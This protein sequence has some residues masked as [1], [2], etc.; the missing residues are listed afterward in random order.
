MLPNGLSQ[1]KIDGSTIPYVQQAKNLGLLMTPSLNCQPQ[2]TSITNKVYT[3][4]SN[5]SLNFSLRKPLI[6]T[7]ALPHFG[8][9]SI[10]FMN[11]G[12]T[13]ALALQA[14]YTR[15]IFGNIPRIPTTNITS[16]LTQCR[17]HLDKLSIVCRHHLKLASLA[18]S[19]VTKQHPPYLLARLKYTPILLYDRR[20]TRTPRQHFEYTVRRTV[21]WKKSFTISEKKLLNSHAITEFDVQRLKEFKTWCF[22]LFF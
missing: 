14:A 17:L 16:H 18:Y 22:Q 20:P 13:R 12:V 5:F 15:F 2:I 6:Q 11:S 21:P 9:A 4:Q 1:I 10:T 3:K 7:F 8:Y 19:V